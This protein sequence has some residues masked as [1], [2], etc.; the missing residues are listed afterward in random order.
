MSDTVS[1]N[2]PPPHHSKAEW[3]PQSCPPKSL[4]Q[5]PLALSSS[6][7]SPLASSCSLSARSRSRRCPC[8]SCSSSARSCSLASVLGRRIRLRVPGSSRQIVLGT[9]LQCPRVT[10]RRIPV[11]LRLASG[12]STDR[13]AGLVRLLSLRSRDSPGDYAGE[14]RGSALPLGGCKSP[15]LASFVLYS[16]VYRGTG[17]IPRACILTDLLSTRPTLPSAPPTGRTLLFARARAT[18]TLAGIARFH[19]RASPRRRRGSP[20]RTP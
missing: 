2:L 4:R 16:R 14:P 19:G 1:R 15:L 13:S 9:L 11:R 5:D 10:S 6:S 12:S 17:P 8:R 7:R 3:D 18:P 20:V